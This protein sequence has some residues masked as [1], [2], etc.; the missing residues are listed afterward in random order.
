MLVFD[1]CFMLNNRLKLISFSWLLYGSSIFLYTFVPFYEKFL[2]SEQYSF[3]IQKVFLALLCLYSI[4]ILLFKKD[5]LL[6]KERVYIMLSG[7]RKIGQFLFRSLQKEIT[8]SPE[9]KVSLLLFLVK[10]YFLPMMAVFL[11]NDLTDILHYGK[12]L[13]FEMNQENIFYYLY[14]LAL[15][16]IFFIDTIYFS[17]G[18]VTESHLLGNTVVSVENTIFGWLVMLACYPPFSGITYDFFGWHSEHFRNFGDVST[19][20]IMG[21]VALFLMSLYLWATISLG[22]KASN[23][24]NRGIVSRGAYKFVR[25]PAYAAKNL[26]W[27]IMG[28]PL[29]F[30][31]EMIQTFSN[32]TPTYFILNDFFPKV[33]VP[34]LSLSIWSFIYYLRAIT[35]ER[36]LSQDPSYRSYMKEVPYRFIPKVW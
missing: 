11:M 31:S 8:F 3:L 36:H 22:S 13:P 28:V 7:I 12:F 19:N 2:Q 17:I 32:S 18:Y 26:A 4:F 24:T 33:V 5:F 15:G 27:W 25:H 9:E 1:P 14:P 29:I 10:F 16:L 21:A 23:L 34:F 35:E 30:S 6:E 20:V